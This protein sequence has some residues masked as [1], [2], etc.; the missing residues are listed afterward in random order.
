[1]PDSN[2]LDAQVIRV[3]TNGKEMWFDPGTPY[4]PFA[5]LRWQ[6]S[7]VQGVL[8]K[9]NNTD[10]FIRT[11]NPDSRDA[12]TK[13]LLTLKMTDSGFK[14]DVAVAYYGL[15]A[16][17]KR[18]EEIENDEATVR[19]E[20]EDELKDSLPGGSTVKLTSLDNLKEADKPLIVGFDVTLPDF[21]SSVGSRRLV[22]LAVLEMGDR[23]PFQ[24]E[25]RKHPVYYHY[26]FQEIERVTLELPAG[27]TVET[28]PAPRLEQ[29]AFGHYES[30]WEKKANTVVLTRTFA[31]LGVFFKTD[32]YPA[33]RDFYSKAATGDQ[34]NVVLRSQQSAG[35]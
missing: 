18:L 12:I 15:G 30:T 1:M 7:G 26:P 17:E 13:R 22:P 32:Y 10:L 2:Q 20:L 27:M 5:M 29:P 14:A 21:T 24:H 8:L 28:A 25:T 9:K 4:T 35:K 16:L 11:P 6:R 34:D 3:T 33:L 31:V 19:Q 23:N